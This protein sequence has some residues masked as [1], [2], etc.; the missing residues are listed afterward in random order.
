VIDASILVPF[1]KKTYL[2]IGQKLISP[3]FFILFHTLSQFSEEK[4]GVLKD[5]RTPEIEKRFHFRSS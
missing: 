5:T 4:N 1:L 3:F 2:E